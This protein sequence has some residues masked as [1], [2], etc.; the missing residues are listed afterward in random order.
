MRGRRQRGVHRQ[1]GRV[2]QHDAPGR[3]E[4]VAAATRQEAH[5]RR[6]RRRRTRPDL[7]L[8][9]AGLGAAAPHRLARGTQLRVRQGDR[10]A[11][12][13]MSRAALHAEALAAAGGRAGPA[14]TQLPGTVVPAYG[15]RYSVAPWNRHHT[16]PVLQQGDNCAGASCACC[17]ARWLALLQ[18]CVISPVLCGTLAC[19][20]GWDFAAAG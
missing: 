13:L 5:G 7:T 16:S 3:L 10:P 12:D 19:P 20:A 4:D 17:A 8:A 1:P 9:L 14:A 2:R 15:W 18:L 6:G 11:C